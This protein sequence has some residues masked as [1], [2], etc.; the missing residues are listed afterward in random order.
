MAD[1]EA[2]KNWALKIINSRLPG[3]KIDILFELASEIMIIEALHLTN[4]SKSQAAKLLGT[5]RTT[6]VDKIKN[7]KIEIPKTGPEKSLNA[8]LRDK[9]LKLKIDEHGNRSNQYVRKYPPLSK[10]SKAILEAFS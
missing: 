9:G 1:N 2:I 7:Y 4:G 5:S 3:N 8:K 10:R 6:L